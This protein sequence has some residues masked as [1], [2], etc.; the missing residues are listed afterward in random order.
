M[1]PNPLVVLKN[2]TVPVG[3]AGISESAAG[4]ARIDASIEPPRVGTGKREDAWLDRCREKFDRASMRDALLKRNEIA[5]AQR[6]LTASAAWTLLGELSRAARYALDGAVRCAG[7]GMMPAV[8]PPRWPP[9]IIYPTL[10]RTVLAMPRHALA[11]CASLARA[12]LRSGAAHP[13]CLLASHG[14]G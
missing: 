6:L 2:F 11:A 3:I 1:N 5:R 4:V 7:C 10:Q 13:A 9:R 14:D 8:D 12:R